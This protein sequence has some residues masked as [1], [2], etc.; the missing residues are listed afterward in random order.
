AARRTDRKA[1]APA[2]GVHTRVRVGDGEVLVGGSAAGNEWVTFHLAGPEDV[3]LHAR[4]VP[5]AHVILR[6]E[7]GEPA[8][9]MIEA[10]AGI[11]A[12]KSAA[13]DAGAVEVDYTLRKYV[14]KIRGGAAGLVTYRNERTIAVAPRLPDLD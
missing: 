7:S 5:G 13:R 8:G 14:R 6:T 1:T 3:W 2:S 10:A 12:A 9:T 4:G 11:A